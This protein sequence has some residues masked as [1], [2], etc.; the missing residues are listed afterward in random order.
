M[1][2]QISIQFEEVSVGALLVDLTA[3]VSYDG[4]RRWS[5]DRVVDTRA[6]DDDGEAVLLGGIQ[7]YAI[8][9]ALRADKRR[10]RRV[11]DAIAAD[12]ADAAIWFSGR[13]A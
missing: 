8:E 3:E 10:A 4:V 12:M 6:T 5:V 13:A 2:N 1:G 9:Q 7:P 11:E